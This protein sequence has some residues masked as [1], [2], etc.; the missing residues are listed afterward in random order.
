MASSFIEFGGKGIWDSDG[1]VRDLLALLLVELEAR[2]LRRKQAELWEHW[3]LQAYVILT[4]THDLGLDLYVADAPT[5]KLVIDCCESVARRTGKME[6]PRPRGFD[7]ADSE[8][9]EGSE[10]FIDLEEVRPLALQVTRLLRGEAGAPADSPE[11]LHWREA[12]AS[13]TPS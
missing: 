11:A 12:K 8:L 7:H 4:G 10:R 2:G 13:E 5:R 1:A 6:R 9:F 3:T